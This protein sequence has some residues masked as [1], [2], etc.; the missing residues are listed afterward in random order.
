MHVTK[1]WFF[2]FLGFGRPVVVD[3]AGVGRL[4]VAVLAHASGS[5]VGL[6]SSEVSTDT[7]TP[8]PAETTHGGWMEG[9]RSKMGRKASMNSHVHRPRPVS[10]LVSV[11]FLNLRTTEQL[12]TRYQK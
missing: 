5:D 6:F 8:L 7:E 2:R 11:T 4:A 12:C 3:G 1:S 9:S 10:L